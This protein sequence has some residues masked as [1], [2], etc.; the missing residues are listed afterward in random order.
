MDQPVIIHGIVSTSKYENN[1]AG[2][3]EKYGWEYDYQV[4]LFG[5]RDVVGGTVVDFIVKSVPLPTPVYVGSR[6]W[7]SGARAEWEKVLDVLINARLRKYY[8][9]PIRLE[10]QEV[11]TPE[12]SDRSVL[13]DFGRMG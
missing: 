5:G 3:L 11:D 7:H 4:S 10:D 9:A 1:Y 13:R 8:Q 12:A 6:H 2:S